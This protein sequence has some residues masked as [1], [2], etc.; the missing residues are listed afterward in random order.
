[1]PCST[2]ALHFSFR[3]LLLLGMISRATTINAMVTPSMIFSFFVH[4]V[5]G[6]WMSI[7]L[8]PRSLLLYPVTLNL[9]QERGPVSS[10]PLINTLVGICLLVG[11]TFCAEEALRNLIDAHRNDT[12][13]ACCVIFL[14]AWNAFQGSLIELSLVCFCIAKMFRKKAARSTRPEYICFSPSP[15]L[16]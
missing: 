8:S 5:S 11:R 6:L 15:K 3:A 1:M 10:L 13:L 4:L 14:L 2:S 12:N 7:V 16:L 9:L